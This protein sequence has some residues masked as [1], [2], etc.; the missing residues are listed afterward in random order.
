MWEYYLSMAETAFLWENI[1]VFQIQIARRQTAIPLTRDYL[2]EAE[3]GL[4]KTD[5][6]KNYTA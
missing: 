1:A 3:E 4:K 6:R 2:K 5:S